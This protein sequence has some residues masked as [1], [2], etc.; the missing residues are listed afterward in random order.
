MKFIEDAKKVRFDEENHI[1]TLNGKE[2]LSI[3]KFIDCYSW[4]FDP[5][6]SVLKRC[7]LK[8]GI[9]EE[10]LAARWKNKGTTAAQSGT[11]WHSSVEHYIKT[12][13]ILNNEYTDLLEKFAKYKF[14]G[15]IFSECRVFSPDLG[16]CGTADFVQIINNKTLIIRDFK[17]NEKRPTDYSF[18][19]KM[20]PPL[21]HLNDSKLQKYELQISIYLFLLSS[22]YNL[23]VGE[24]HCLY[25]IDRKK[26]NIE[27]IPITYRP[28][29]VIEMIADWTYNKSLTPEQ[30]AALE[31]KKEDW[32]D[33][34]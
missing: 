1:Y 7:A 20:K 16:L 24:G 26:R 19:K 14:Q 30:R 23:H 4:P 27:E 3:T 15:Q 31:N 12:K 9:S 18:G 5:D 2:L 34:L 21:E 8:E 25:W 13:E 11:F 22:E 10:I 29:E 32:E 33:W 17:T 28:K 6:G